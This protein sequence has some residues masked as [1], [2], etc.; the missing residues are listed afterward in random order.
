M[1][2]IHTMSKRIL[3]V[4]GEVA[5]EVLAR[6]AIGDSSSGMESKPKDRLMDRREERRRGAGATCVIEGE[7]LT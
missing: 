7:I 2:V 1:H 5:G 3:H 4:S 6:L